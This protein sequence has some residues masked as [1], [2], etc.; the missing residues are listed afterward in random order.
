MLLLC[1]Q[2]RMLMARHLQCAGDASLP[3]IRRVGIASLYGKGLSETGGL[4]R[5]PIG[6]RPA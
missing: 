1:N 5:D 4:T 2:S 3:P 6:Q